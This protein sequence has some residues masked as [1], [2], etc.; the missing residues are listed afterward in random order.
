MNANQ[1]MI[2]S[3][4]MR[5]YPRLISLLP[6]IHHMEFATGLSILPWVAGKRDLPYMIRSYCSRIELSLGEPD[7]FTIRCGF[8]GLN[9]TPAGA[10]ITGM[11]IVSPRCSFPRDVEDHR[12]P[13]T[14]SFLG[15]LHRQ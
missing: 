4:M 12:C 1:K 6:S 10:E 15:W 3:A 5:S 14:L 9:K 7:Q 2:K 13:L 8:S 11:R